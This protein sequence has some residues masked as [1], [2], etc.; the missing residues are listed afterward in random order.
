MENERVRGTEKTK[1]GKEK[2]MKKQ[3]K[4]SFCCFLAFVLMFTS[5]Q[6]AEIGTMIRR[7]Y[8]AQET[9]GNQKEVIDAESTKNSTTFQLAG[10][11]KQTVFYGQDVRFED[12]DGK[13]KDYDPSLVK[14]DGGKSESGKDLKEYQY[15]NKEGDKKHYLPKDLTIETPVLMENGDY[16]ISFAPIYGE[17][18]EEQTASDQN[19]KQDEQSKSEEAS[20]E[21]TEE[22]T[23]AGEK[24]AAEKTASN[25]VSAAAVKAA[26]AENA[27]ADIQKLHRGAVEEEEVL[28][29]E[30]EKEELPVKVSYESE[31][32]EY[33]FVYQSLDTGVKESITLYE[34]PKEN[35]LQFQ[36]YAKGMKAKKNVLDGGI[37]FLDKETEDIVASLEAPNMNDASGSAY[38]EAVSYEIEP[39]EG[40]EDTY[41]LTL[42]LD[43]NYM[44]DSDRKYPV[45]IDPTV[46]WKGSTDF[47]DV[48][49][50][51]DRKDQPITQELRS[52]VRGLRLIDCFT[53]PFFHECQNGSA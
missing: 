24:G 42:V 53:E 36:F 30:N 46:T 35:K 28:N 26:A 23:N 12:E 4:R 5:I 41:R 32:Q 22:E 15:T 40:E 14:V 11:K 38:S 44:K 39:I 8:G 43:E 37:T 52:F 51:N 6:W 20:A 17:T 49:V 7:I 16:V 21:E 47:W 10:G 25:Q 34:A 27:F 18:K 45:T 1:Y 31:D 33:A 48:Y 9:Q 2:R 29:A 19:E 13:L 3:I 50:I